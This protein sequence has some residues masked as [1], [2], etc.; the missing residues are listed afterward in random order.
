[1]ETHDFRE[2]GRHEN[3]LTRFSSVERTLVLCVCDWRPLCWKPSWACVECLYGGFPS[4][5]VGEGQDEIEYERINVF[6]VLICRC[7]QKRLRLPTRSG[8]T[9]HCGPK[10]LVTFAWTAAF[11]RSSLSLSLSRMLRRSASYAAAAGTRGLAARKS[12][13][14]AD[15]EGHSV[16]Q[17]VLLQQIN[18]I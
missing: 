14:V 3:V 13:L 8:A 6:V 7:Q 15:F 10:S 1:M 11:Q 18:F 5:R 4:R 2:I 16:W 9:Q 17:G 12:D